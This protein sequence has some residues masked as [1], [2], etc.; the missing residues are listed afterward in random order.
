MCANRM[1]WG[2]TAADMPFGGLSD[3]STARQ[4]GNGEWLV[5]CLADGRQ[6][7]LHAAAAAAVEAP[8]A[9]DVAAEAPAAAQR[10]HLAQQAPRTKTAA[11]PPPGRAAP[12]PLP[13]PWLS[14]CRPSCPPSWKELP[15]GW[16]PIAPE[17][18]AAPGP[19]L[20][21]PVAPR[22]R[23]SPCCL[24]GWCCWPWIGAPWARGQGCPLGPC[25]WSGGRVPPPRRSTPPAAAPPAANAFLRPA[26][27]GFPL[28]GPACSQGAAEHSARQVGAAPTAG[29]R[30][31]GV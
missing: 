20:A 21:P 14:P 26:L 16:A 23:C 13:C 30:R 6:V 2:A 28:G 27:G 24:W 8:A 17:T 31:Y 25:C 4:S 12:P 18:A 19:A 15:R 22:Q 7:G 5:C 10:A 3:A 29:E 11:S 9:A 1:N